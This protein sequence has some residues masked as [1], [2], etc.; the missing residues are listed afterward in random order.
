MAMRDQTITRMMFKAAPDQTVEITFE[1]VGTTF[2]LSSE[3]YIF[4]QLQESVVASLELVV[5]PNGV[6]VWVPYPGNYVILNS[7]G[8]ELDR[9]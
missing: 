3:E 9:L 2:R 8:A 7:E 1:P 5:W 6:G 4:L